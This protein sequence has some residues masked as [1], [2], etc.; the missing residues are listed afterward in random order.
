MIGCLRTRVRKQPIIALYITSRPGHTHL[1]V[2]STMLVKNWA[3]TMQ[4]TWHLLRLFIRSNLE[5]VNYKTMDFYDTHI[6]SLT[7]LK[8]IPYC[9]TALFE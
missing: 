5:R 2:Q 9:F 6:T 7:T 8:V 1:L 4:I 3:L